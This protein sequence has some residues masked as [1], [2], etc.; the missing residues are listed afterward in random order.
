MLEVPCNPPRRHA[1][2]FAGLR[3]V[4]A[5]AREWIVRCSLSAVTAPIPIAANPTKVRCALSVDADVG[6]VA[7]CSPGDGRCQERASPRRQR[8]AATWS[9]RV[10]RCCG[11]WRLRMP[12]HRATFPISLREPVASFAHNTIYGAIGSMAMLASGFLATVITARMLGP[13]AFG[14]IAFATTLVGMSLALIDLGLP[15]A[16]TRFLPELRD[17]NTGAARAMGHGA[18][19]FR[20]AQR[21]GIAGAVSAS[22]L[23]VCRSEAWAPRLRAR[24][25][26]ASDAEPRGFPLCR[27]EGAASV[28]A[29][30]STVVGSLGSHR[31]ASRISVRDGSGS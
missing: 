17:E 10:R 26:I 31:S 20:D 6:R 19:A 22:P 3:T 12:V 14:V 16:M 13:H 24:C 21:R 8:T 1:A 2:P 18:P 7:L 4:H 30:R 27:S 29:L 9:S 23:P 5:L 15:G 25:Y 11:Y 28:C